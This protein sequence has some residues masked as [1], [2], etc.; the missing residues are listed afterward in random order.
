MEHDIIK[1]IKKR[2]IR[3]W[4]KKIL[5]FIK[6]YIP[7]KLIGYYYQF[8]HNIIIVCGVIIILFNNNLWHLILCL[9][10]VS[11]DGIANIVCHD[12]PLTTLEK[13]YLKTSLCHDRKKILKK[14]NISYK[15]N[16]I[17]ESQLELIVNVWALIVSKILIII[18]I[19]TFSNQII[20]SL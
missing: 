12:C 11:L 7:K 9:L 6:K 3:S 4:S 16:H 2:K 14:L 1:N 15:C 5:K 19:S 20:I 17:Y 8:L 10:I 13:K 18:L